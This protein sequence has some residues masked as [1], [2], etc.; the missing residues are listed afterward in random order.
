MENEIIDSSASWQPILPG[1]LSDIGAAAN[2]A[3]AR[4]RFADYHQRRAQHT[5]RRQYSDLALFSEFLS[6]LG[7][8][9]GD[10]FNEPDAWI[11]ITWGLVEAFIKWQLKKGYAVSTVNVRLSTIKAYSRLA[12]QAGTMNPQ[13][14][15]LI[16][17]VQGYTHKEQVRID[18]KRPVHRL[19]NKKALPVTLTSSDALALKQHANNPQGRRDTLMMCLLLDHGLRVGELA[20]LCV[21]NIELD[22]GL[23]HF[24][25]QKVS[26]VQIHRMSPDTLKAG[27]KYINFADALVTGPLLRRS[28]RNGELGSAGITTRGITQRV[29]FLG[30]KIGVMK[31][32][33][34][35]C[36]HYWATMAA[37]HGTDTFS[38]QEAGG[39]ASLAMPR[40]YVENNNIAN[41]GIILD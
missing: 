3:A 16:R 13:E 32:S 15:A 38:L 40:R 36:R 29:N 33:A 41:D 27:Q 5:I 34:H 12:M 7:L 35:D 31:L 30:E 25:R 18:K 37:R 39:W 22:R 4:H 21:E 28:K 26:K 19:G 6:T 9:A 11:V 14:Y 2:N 1:E 24:Y 10:L 17:S 23:L 8:S 20:D